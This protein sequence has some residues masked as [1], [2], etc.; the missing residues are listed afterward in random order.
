MKNVLFE[1][2][3]AAVRIAARHVYHK[4][5]VMLGDVVGLGKTLMA[6]ATAKILEEEHGWQTLILCPKNLE[7]MWEDQRQKYIL[8]GK[9]IPISQVQQQ[10]PDLRRH[11][12]VIID[13]SHNLRNPFGKRYQIVKDYISQN[14]SKCILLS[15]TPYNKTYIDLIKP[16]RTFY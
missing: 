1:F 13:E 9:V 12:I 6:I 4:N 14:D 10:L 8:S 16:V 3:S 11:H 5:G 15:A 2:Q 7:G